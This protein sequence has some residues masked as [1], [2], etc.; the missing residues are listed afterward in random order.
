MD[1]NTL[2]F[3]SICAKESKDLRTT[4]PHVLPIYPTSS[5]QF[6]D[7]E[8]GIAAFDGK[9]DVHMYTRYGNPT[10]DAVADKL[11]R[12]ESYGLE[13]EA[14]AYLTGSGMAAISVLLTGLL[15]AG[16]K[17]LTQENLY[18]G[19]TMYMTQILSKQGVEVE[20]IDFKNAA[21][22]EEKMRTDRR[23]K[24][25]YI[26]SPANP[27]MALTDLEYV[28]ALGR[29]YGILTA[30]DNTFCTPFI[31]Q[32]FQFGIDFVVHS[33]TKFLNGHG[34]SIAGAIVSV[35]RDL[36][37]TKIFTAL[38]LSGSICSPFEA[39]LLHNGLKT[40]E[41]RMTRHS[42]NAQEVAEYLERHPGVLRVNYNGLPSHPDHELAQKQMGMY[43]GMLSFELKG[44]IQAGL[45]FM[46]RVR[47]CT[48]APTLGDTD[49]LIMHPASM[50][51]RGIERT[52]RER[53]GITDGLIRMSVGIENA[54]DILAD[55]ETALNR[56]S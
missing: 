5:F 52:V 34:N 27:V 18:G 41:L 37:Q 45:E 40:L 7:I 30:I 43:G 22:L 10:T 13:E 46:N 6:A 39:W 28:G 55:L 25:V 53:N 21:L 29:T 35:R 42:E 12:L 36:M 48:I 50:S 26:E 8:Q 15:E 56:N 9:R 17:V 23:I 47:F 51:H 49:T 2:G 38:K 1:K 3:G 19:T 24:L 44:G 54:A 4:K 32:P 31:Q 20:M 14:T 11:A 33:A 16:D